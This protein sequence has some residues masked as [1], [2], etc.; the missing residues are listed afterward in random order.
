MSFSHGPWLALASQTKKPRPDFENPDGV[1][2]HLAIHGPSRR[3]G[4]APAEPYPPAR[5]GNEPK[6]PPAVSHHLKPKLKV[7]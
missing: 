4:C 5:T 6:T 1:G 7:L 2:M 3:S